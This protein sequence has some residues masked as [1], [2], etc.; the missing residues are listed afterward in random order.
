MVYACVRAYL[1]GACAVLKRQC[2]CGNGH[3][4]GAAPV[5]TTTSSASR[6]RACVAERW[7][8]ICAR[9]SDMFCC[10]WWCV[11]ERGGSDVRG[12]RHPA[13][14]DAGA[15][16]LLSLSTMKSWLDRLGTG[17]SS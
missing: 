7:P 13:S 10:W 3:G 12:T 8:E 14:L 17:S 1:A 11:G 5:M 16:L 4:T 15:S 9:R 2:V 6:P